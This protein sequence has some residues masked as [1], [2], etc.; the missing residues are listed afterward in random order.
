MTKKEEIKQALGDLTDKDLI[1]H[2][3]TVFLPD[4]VEL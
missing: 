3:K 1:P 4:S 2:Y